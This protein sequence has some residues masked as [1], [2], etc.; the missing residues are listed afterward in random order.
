MYVD[1]WNRTHL[2][3]KFPISLKTGWKQKVT[4]NL[5]VN[6][7][8]NLK[9]GSESRSVWHLIQLFNF[10]RLIFSVFIRP[11]HGTLG[12]IKSYQSMNGKF[13][14]H[15]QCFTF[16]IILWFYAILRVFVLY[17]HYGYSI[18]NEKLNGHQDF[19]SLGLLGALTFLI[20]QHIS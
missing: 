16:L 9:S 19:E 3:Y 11:L 2:W 6:P 1:V 15:P 14:E 18:S 12:F 8:L 4:L 17:S 7:V 20:K 10:C 13:V 5:V